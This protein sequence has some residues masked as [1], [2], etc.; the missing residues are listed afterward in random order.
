MIKKIFISPKKLK[1]FKVFNF[2]SL[3]YVIFCPDFFGYVK[4]GFI[5]NGKNKV[6]MNDYN[7]HM[8]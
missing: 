6:K 8:V 2:S 7:T 3:R 4:K 5:R 1:V